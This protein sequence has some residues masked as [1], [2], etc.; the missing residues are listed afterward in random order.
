MAEK[1]QR[2]LGCYIAAN[3]STR[4]YWV[5]DSR[6][7]NSNGVTIEKYTLTSQQWPPAHLSQHST[8]WQH[9]LTIYRPDTL[10]TDKALLFINGGTRNASANL[11]NSAAAPINFLRIALAT[12]S[13]VADLQDNPNQYLTFDDDT[14]R[15]EDSITAYTWARYLEDSY[16]HVFWP[17]QLP[18]TLSAIKAMD[19]VQAI[20]AQQTNFHIQHFV[21]SGA[22][23]RGW[24]T[25]LTAIADDRVE[26]IVPVVIDILN[27]NTNL[28]HIY[29]SYDNHW[30]PAFYD[31]IHANIT[32]KMDTPAFHQLRKIIDPIA[33]QDCYDCNAYRIR[34]GIPKYIISASGD[35]FFVPDSIN[36]YWDKLSGEKI[37]RVVPNQS[38][39]IS[40][41]VV[42]DAL[43][44]YYH[45]LIQHTPRPRLYWKSANGIPYSVITDTTPVSAKLW[46][47]ENPNARDFRLAAHVTYQSH[48]LS[49]NCTNGQCSFPVNI[50]PP[51]HGWKASFVELTFHL[52][53]GEEFVRTTP[54]Y[55]SHG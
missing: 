21:I 50:T 48:E 24:A 2:V 45:T 51:T 35:D 16:H 13:V 22:S 41:Q 37:L 38:H 12:H 31:Y 19:A 55:I 20:V 14:P 43:L 6:E 47:A 40:N 34:L 46:E 39:Y 9:N 18:M 52:A 11:S 27:M 28:P 30:P 8:Q 36:M 49:G 10:Q 17:L 54:V 26:A 3:A 53:S 29:A 23:K 4:P 42:E 25:W 44:A 33:Y 15:K 32:D 1:P 5:L 7:H